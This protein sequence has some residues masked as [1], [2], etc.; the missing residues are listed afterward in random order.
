MNTF[1]ENMNYI[2]IQLDKYKIKYRRFGN[3]FQI[4]GYTINY[5]NEGF[6][7]KNEPKIYNFPKATRHYDRLGKS[8]QDHTGFTKIMKK[9]KRAS[10][11]YE[12][13]RVLSQLGLLKDVR[14]YACKLII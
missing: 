8:Y 4:P 1:T 9:I 12:V 2:I 7:I 3:S 5:R 6:A 10:D 13:Y 14:L 11:A